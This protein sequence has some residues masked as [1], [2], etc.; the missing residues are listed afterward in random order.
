MMDADAL[1]HIQ[2]KGTADQKIL[3]ATALKYLTPKEILEV[4]QSHAL[5][6]EEKAYQ[7]SLKERRDEDTAPD[8]G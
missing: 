1:I 5:E 2:L 4:Q 7:E 3:G 8:I 6:N